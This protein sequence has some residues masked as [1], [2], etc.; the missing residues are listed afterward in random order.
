M[1]TRCEP[2]AP[3]QK[4]KLWLREKAFLQAHERGKRSFC[5]ADPCENILLPEPG[6]APPAAPK[7]YF[8]EAANCLTG[9][10]VSGISVTDLPGGIARPSAPRGRPDRE[11]P[12]R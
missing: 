10:P 11:R 4:F 7:K 12:A 3:L 9:S 6:I 5:G 2:C 8:R 1:Q